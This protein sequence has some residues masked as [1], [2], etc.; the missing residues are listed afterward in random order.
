VE[1]KSRFFYGYIIVL[2]S[3]LTMAIVHGAFYG[4]GIF[5][6]PVMLEFGWTRATTAGAFSL[7]AL[8]YGC[9]GIVAGRLTD[10]FGPRIVMTISIFIL[11][12]GYLLM[13]YIS[14]IWQLYLFYGVFVGCGITCTFVPLTTTVARWFIKRRGLMTGIAI[15]GIGF[16]TMIVPPIANWLVSSYGWRNSYL[17]MS[18][19]ILVLVIPL[20]Q[21]IKRDPNR[22]GL[23]PY[24]K[25][26]RE[27]HNLSVETNVGSFQIASHTK[28]FWIFCTTF[29]CYGFIAGVIIVHIV[30]HATDLA[31]S[32]SGA[33]NILSIVGISSIAG[34][35]IMGS[36]GERTGNKAATFVSYLIMLAALPLILFTKSLWTFYIFAI[37]FGF[38]YGGLASLISLILA[39]F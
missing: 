37:A 9:I 33:A 20:V 22:I 24:G 39:E 36:I 32:T 38:A 8:T 17:V 18:F 16:G 26:Q 31:I 25:N 30:P 12:I 23:E 5:F 14:T 27:Q 11:C 34:R 6:K 1:T 35:I 28:Q 19:L 7:C 3:F 2:V 4:F 15:S 10:K 21:F 13:S 29:L